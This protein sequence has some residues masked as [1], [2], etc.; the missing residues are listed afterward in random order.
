[1]TSGAFLSLKLKLGG[2]KFSKDMETSIEILQKEKNH[3]AS[4]SGSIHAQEK[5]IRRLSWAVAFCF[6][7][8]SAL[9]LCTICLLRSGFPDKKDKVQVD[10]RIEISP[11]GN[12]RPKAHLTGTRQA[13]SSAQDLH[14][15]SEL[16]L[17]FLQGGMKYSNKSIIIPIAGY[18]FVYC[19]LSFRPQAGTCADEKSISQSITRSNSNYP[20]PE[21][22]LSGI[23]F[24]TKARKTYQPIYLGGLLHLQKGDELKVKMQPI[25]PVDTSFDHKTFFGAFLV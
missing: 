13:D 4:N 17:A 9:T 10:K 18:Y 16:G 11:D 3:G 8:L 22:I 1:M 20:D 21:I 6:I 24:C 14:W 19:Q 23:S 2:E 5:S 25:T 15:E 7:L 12:T